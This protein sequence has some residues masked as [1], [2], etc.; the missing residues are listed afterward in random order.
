M[1]RAELP[2]TY[3]DY[4]VDQIVVQ[5]ENKKKEMVSY[6]ETILQYRLTYP[7]MVELIWSYWHEEGMLVQTAN[8]IAL[9]LQNKRLGTRNP[10]AHLKLDHLR[11]LNHLFWGFIQDEINRSSV[12][13]RAVGDDQ[14]SP[15]QTQNLRNFAYT[16]TNLAV[17][18]G[19]TAIGSVPSVNIDDEMNLTQR[20]S[21]YVDNNAGNRKVAYD[22]GPPITGDWVAGDR[23]WN[24]NPNLGQPIGWICINNGSPGDWQP[25]PNL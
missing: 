6:Y 24:T 10:L 23:I 12:H 15:G 19:N 13:H 17:V 21:R 25:M 14:A 4:I 11:P 7:S 22:T 2:F 3:L 20:V 18:G 8:A 1:P 9:R 5:N 16:E